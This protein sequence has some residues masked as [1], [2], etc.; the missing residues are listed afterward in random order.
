MN[1]L[2]FQPIH[3]MLIVMNDPVKHPAS[4][5]GCPSLPGRC[6]H[7][8]QSDLSK[9]LTGLMVLQIGIN[10]IGS[11]ANLIMSFFK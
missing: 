7:Q 8:L 11:L 2:L 5:P 9:I 1:L 3:A 4:I 10:G 6:S